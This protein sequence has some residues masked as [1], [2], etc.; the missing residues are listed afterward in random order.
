MYD[1][2]SDCYD[3]EYLVYTKNELILVRENSYIKYSK[4]QNEWKELES[5]NM[6]TELFDNLREIG[7]EIINNLHFEDRIHNKE[8]DLER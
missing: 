4:T 3:N 1:I 7:E 8:K 5:L 2:T 6:N